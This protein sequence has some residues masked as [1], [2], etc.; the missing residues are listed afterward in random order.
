[1]A[2]V[3]RLTQPVACSS[4][5][6]RPATVNDSIEVA[7]CRPVAILRGRLKGFA[8]IERFRTSRVKNGNMGLW[9]LDLAYT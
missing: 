8:L 2:H 7:C 3:W 5:D 6:R 9:S 1:M 4:S